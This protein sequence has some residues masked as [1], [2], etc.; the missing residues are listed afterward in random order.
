[1]SQ[2]SGSD[3]DLNKDSATYQQSDFDSTVLCFG[4]LI[5]KVGFYD[6]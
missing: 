4:F 6:Y 5:H 3:L 2:H 1:M